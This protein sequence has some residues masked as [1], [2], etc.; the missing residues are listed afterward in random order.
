MLCDSTSEYVVR[1]ALHSSSRKLILTI[2]PQLGGSQL[3]LVYR[4]NRSGVADCRL[5]AQPEWFDAGG[6]EGFGDGR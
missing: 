2:H 4:W 6:V 1:V 3:L 5:S